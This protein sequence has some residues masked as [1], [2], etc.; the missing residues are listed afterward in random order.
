MPEYYCRFPSQASSKVWEP[1]LRIQ[2]ENDWELETGKP[3]PIINPSTG[4]QF[5]CPSNEIPVMVTISGYIGR[6]SSV[7]YWDELYLCS[8]QALNG[9]HSRMLYFWNTCHGDGG[10]SLTHSGAQ[11]GGY[12]WENCFNEGLSGQGLSVATTNGQD[13]YWAIQ[14]R[15][16]TVYK[17]GVTVGEKITKSKMDVLKS[18]M[19][20]KTNGST[21]PTT[22]TQGATATA[23]LANT[24][25]RGTVSQ[26]GSIQASWYNG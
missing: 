13:L 12:Y 11:P 19:Y 16:I 1:D 10:S 26:G 3:L 17:P 15:I 9:P 5:V 20:Y 21:N 14:I 18:Y 2:V 6:W 23:S 4:S 8:S 25:G 24:Y 7:N 22:A